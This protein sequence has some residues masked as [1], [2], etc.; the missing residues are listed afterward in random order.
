MIAHTDASGA[1]LKK[2]ADTGANLATNVSC[3]ALGLAHLIDE[4]YIHRESVP[5]GETE[6]EGTPDMPRGGVRH[7]CQQMG[8]G[9]AAMW[10][11]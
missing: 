3:L 4:S 2:L 7:R 1:D 11:R 8:R 5:W 10:G 9:G 6:F